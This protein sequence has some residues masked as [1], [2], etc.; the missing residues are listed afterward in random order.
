MKTI[1]ATRSYERH[2]W[3]TRRAGVG[4]LLFVCWLAF[5]WPV[6]AQT[7]AT[8]GG[9][10]RTNDQHTSEAELNR[11]TNESSANI[12]LRRGRMKLYGWPLGSLIEGTNRWSRNANAQQ[13]DPALLGWLIGELSVASP[14]LR[15]NAVE[16]LGALGDAQAVEPLIKALKD[17]DSEVRSRAAE[18]LGQLDDARSVGPLI[19]ALRDVDSRVRWAAVVELGELGG[20]R[21]VE[22]LVMALG[23]RDPAVHVGAAWALFK[24]GDARGV[25]PLFKALEDWSPSLDELLLQLPQTA[26]AARLAAPPAGGA[27]WRARFIAGKLFLAE[28]RALSENY[29]GACLRVLLS[30]PSMAYTG[31]LA[32]VFALAGWSWTRSR[33]QKVR[34]IRTWLAGGF[35][36][37]VLMHCL[38]RGPVGLFLALGMGFVPGWFWF[39]WKRR[40]MPLQLLSL[41][42]VLALVVAWLE[43]GYG[44]PFG[45]VVMALGLWLPWC[46][47]PS[48]GETEFGLGGWIA[49][50]WACVFLMLYGIIMRWTWGT[51]VFLTL[52]LTPVWFSLLLIGIGLGL[53]RWP[54]ARQRAAGF[55]C[56]DHFLR[57]APG[58]KLGW[59][60]RWSGRWLLREKNAPKDMADSCVCR[61]CG[62]SSRYEG[63]KKVVGVLDHSGS[64][65]QQKGAVLRVNWLA[66][67]LPFD[68][69]RVEVVEAT[70]TEVEEFVRQM[71]Y[72]AELRTQK[73]LPKMSC[74]VNAQCRFERENTVTLLRQTF[75]SMTKD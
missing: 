10:G 23:D 48:R 16:E 40:R 36:W 66:K 20:E 68:F 43:L 32:L 35:V 52:A 42:W 72:Q 18:A 69:D 38:A 71:R 31:V 45:V 59:V 39:C 47:A 13:S 26:G 53:R 5:A 24:L 60:V 17:Q 22:A 6:G 56:R 8:N 12:R 41:G 50:G 33:Q 73:R 4:L 25:K 34:G 1:I 49:A 30:G 28:P 44:G 46:W 55:V 29:F 64:Y 65:P 9:A 62:K 37:V 61:V 75:G 54:A 51:A 14:S 70:D 67:K 57:L 58:P 3:M 21:A 27:P 2:G 74:V 19:D 15:K 11:L 63:I 7:P